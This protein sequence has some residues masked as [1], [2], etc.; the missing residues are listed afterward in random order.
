MGVRLPT[1]PQ[2]QAREPELRPYGIQERIIDLLGNYQDFLVR[3]ER[4][5][6]GVGFLEQLGRGRQMA[7]IEAPASS[8]LRCPTSAE[9]TRRANGIALYFCPWV[10]RPFRHDRSLG[11]RP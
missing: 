10:I 9:S 6:A 11:G 3:I 7:T 4:V 8:P 1:D 5:L 2:F